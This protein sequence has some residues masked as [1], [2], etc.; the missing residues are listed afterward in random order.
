MHLEQS[1][2]A[3]L[4]AGKPPIMNLSHEIWAKVTNPTTFV[5]GFPS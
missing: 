3:L 2:I 4:I 5:N 1:R